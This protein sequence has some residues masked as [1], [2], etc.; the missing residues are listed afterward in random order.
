MDESNAR[1]RPR[2]ASPTP[3]SG[4]TLHLKSLRANGIAHIRDLSQRL[5]E[6]ELRNGALN[7][8]LKLSASHEPSLSLDDDCLLKALVEL[9]F[10]TMGWKRST[11]RESASFQSKDAWTGHVTKV[12][13]LQLSSLDFLR[14]CSCLL[15]GSFP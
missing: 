7:D 11:V 3:G 4:T 10:E 9:Y 12:N 14:L 6:A 2:S 5:K 8:L 13:G 1:K 15:R